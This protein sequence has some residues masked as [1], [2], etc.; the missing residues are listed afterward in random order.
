MCLSAKPSDGIGCRMTMDGNMNLVRR[1]NAGRTYRDPLHQNRFIL[2]QAEV[3]ALVDQQE[4]QS[5]EDQVRMHYYYP[6]FATIP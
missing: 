6:E 4:T 3:D 2:P 5:K 1:A